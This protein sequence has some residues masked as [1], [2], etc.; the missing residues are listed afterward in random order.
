[1]P[2]LFSRTASTAFRIALGI[3]AG[4]A[5]AVPV[6][7]MFWVRT[8][9]VTGQHDAPTQPVAFSHLI[10]A[11]DLQ[12]DC[13]YCHTDVERA[14]T[15]G[16]PATQ[17]CVPCHQP[18]WYRGPMFA[19]VRQSLDSNRPIQWKRV[20]DLPDYVFFNHAI[21]VTKGVPCQS[22]HGRVDR[23]SRVAQT[24]PLTMGWCLDCHRN[25]APH[26]RPRTEVTAMGWKPAVPQARLGPEL[27]RAYH[28]RSVT[29]CSACH[30]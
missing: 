14:A 8:P 18:V 5:I 13:R 25:P 23:M 30:R 3:G 21:H 17:V 6:L 7:L 12:I 4:A 29:D 11:G 1:M 19:A 9:P 27:M 22:C 28:V 10:H 20:N 2:A 26:L 24:A 15:A 16:M